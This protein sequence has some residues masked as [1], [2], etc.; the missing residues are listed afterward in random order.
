[1]TKNQVVVVPPRVSKE[2]VAAL[3]NDLK[4][5]KKNDTARMC[6]QKHL[7]EVQDP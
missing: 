2:D 3:H 1:M 4:K 6:V 7:S 5:I